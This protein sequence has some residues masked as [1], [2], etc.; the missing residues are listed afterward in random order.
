MHEQRARQVAAICREIEAAETMPRLAALA[1]R[2]RM[3]PYHFHR[4]FKAVTGLTPRAFATANRKA[5]V[6]QQLV[7][8]DTT[9][10]DAIYSAGFN[11]GGRFY[12]SSSALLGMTPTAYREGGPGLEIRFAVGHCSLGSILVAQ[13]SKGVCAI[14]LG[15]NPKEL[16]HELEHRFPRAALERGDESFEQVVSQVIAF[17]DAPATGLNLPLDIRGTVFQQRVWQVLRTIAPGETATY[18]EVAA[19]IGAPEATRA[20]AQACGANPLAVAIPCHRVIKKDG[21]ISGYRWGVERKRQLLD[22]ETGR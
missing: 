17:V 18:T 16:V 15:D 8:R 20:V 1:A 14:L 9:V 11:S 12:E 13:T 6:Q 22:K 2:A 21:A 4:L 19:R 7:R 10:T 5:R 3:S